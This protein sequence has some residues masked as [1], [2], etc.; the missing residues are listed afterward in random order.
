MLNG[1]YGHFEYLIKAF[2]YDNNFAIGYLNDM[3]D[4]EFE[5]LSNNLSGEYHDLVHPVKNIEK[6]D[7]Y[8]KLKK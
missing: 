4:L 3:I 2:A 1:N 8:L 6:I 5:H 7:Y